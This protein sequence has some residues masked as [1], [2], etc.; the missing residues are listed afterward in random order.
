MRLRVGRTRKERPVTPELIRFHRRADVEAATDRPVT[1]QDEACRMSPAHFWRGAESLEHSYEHTSYLP[2]GPSGT[3]AMPG[4]PVA[5]GGQTALLRGRSPRSATASASGTFR[6]SRS[7]KRSAA[8]T[9]EIGCGIATDGLEVRTSRGAIYIGTDLTPHGIELARERRRLYRRFEVANAE[10][11]LPLA[12]AVDHVY[13]FGVIHHSPVPEKIVREMHRVLRRGGTFTV[14]L[15]TAR[16]SITTW[17]SCAC[18]SS[19]G[20]CCCPLHAATDCRDWRLRSLEAGR[21]P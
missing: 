2:S 7:S 10:E 8:R 18:A 9:C 20:G 12:D 19:S 13:S 16:R 17:R 15:H 14:M 5:V 11:R 1:R 3:I 6:S 4:G 21:P